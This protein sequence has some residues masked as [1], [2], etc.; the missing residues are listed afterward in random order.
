MRPERSERSLK[1]VEKPLLVGGRVRAKMQREKAALLFEGQKESHLLRV[2]SF[3]PEQPAERMIRKV[4]GES[5]KCEIP[6]GKEE[7]DLQE[8][9]KKEAPAI[10]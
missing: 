5:A 10:F 4:G 8:V 9:R 2:A 3:L 6:K 7:V 1:G